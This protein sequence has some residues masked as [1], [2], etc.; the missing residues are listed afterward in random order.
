MKKIVVTVFA[1]AV[2]GGATLLVGAGVEFY[3]LIEKRIELYRIEVKRKQISLEA[4]QGWQQER[5]N[6][7]RPRNTESHHISQAEAEALADYIDKH[8]E[9]FQAQP[10]Q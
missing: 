7:S 10:K 6:Y 2:L 1:I 5:D 9:E 4:E 3:R 8:P